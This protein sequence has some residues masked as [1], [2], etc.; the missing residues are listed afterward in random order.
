MMSRPM[1]PRALVNVDDDAMLVPDP[2]TTAADVPANVKAIVEQAVVSMGLE[3]EKATKFRE[4]SY[5]DHR[6]AALNG[7][8]VTH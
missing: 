8:G 2:K 7:A 1:R 5:E 4:T 6:K 3:G